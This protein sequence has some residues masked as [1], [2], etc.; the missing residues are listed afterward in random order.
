MRRHRDRGRAQVRGEDEPR[1]AREADRVRRVV[2]PAH[3]RRARVLG[4]VAQRRVGPPQLE[5]RPVQGQERARIADLAR[6]AVLPPVARLRQPRR[7]VLAV[8]VAGGEAER[9]TG[10]RPGQGH[11]AA[12][13]AR[14]RPA[15][16]PERGV[17]ARLV[18]QL[19]H[20][21]QAEFITL[22]DVGRAGQRQHQQRRRAGPPRPG[23]QL[24]VAHPGQ[25]GGL[26]RCP[27]PARRVTAD[28]AGHVMVADHPGR[29]VAARHALDRL[30]RFPHLGGVPAGQDE[31][32]VEDLGQP[33]L[34]QVGHQRRGGVVPDLPDR[35]AR[36]GEFP[37]HVGVED[38]PP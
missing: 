1:L 18:G 10:S 5:R 17:L 29:A 2:Q 8:P 25:P 3:E 20:F 6:D 36:A 19:D 35:G 9:G 31:L 15:G 32:E 14:G 7:R 33:A 13:A 24:G 23:P 27:R 30:D 16:P 37:G 12:V 4:P 38:D 21:R 11:P 22:V 34:G 28:R 26:V